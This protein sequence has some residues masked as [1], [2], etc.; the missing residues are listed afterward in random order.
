MSKAVGISE[1]P[2][3]EI[4]TEDWYYKNEN[5]LVYYITEG[6]TNKI[7][8]VFEV[9]K[10]IEEFEFHCYKVVAGPFKY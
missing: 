4:S 5:P 3:K 7:F 9:P 1:F 8:A 2:D 10:E 6:K